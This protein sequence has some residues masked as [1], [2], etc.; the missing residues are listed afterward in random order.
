LR[1][2]VPVVG[3]LLVRKI[4]GR[5]KT[6]FL[7]VVE[8]KNTREVIGVGKHL[9]LFIVLY[10]KGAMEGITP[11]GLLSEDYRFYWG[12]RCTKKKDQTYCT[13]EVILCNQCSNEFSK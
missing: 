1:T 4:I 3:H 10:R 5:K 8:N 11:E 12:C 6:R 2:F 9:F 13:F 7:F